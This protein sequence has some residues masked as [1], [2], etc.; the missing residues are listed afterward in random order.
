MAEQP[1][2]KRERYVG[3]SAYCLQLAKVSSD[4]KSRNTLRQM[5]SEWLK[6]AE[7][8]IE[9]GLTTTTDG[10]PQTPRSSAQRRPRLCRRCARVFTEP[11]KIKRDGIAMK[12][13]RALREHQGPRE[14]KVTAQRRQ[15]YVDG[16]ERQRITCCSAVN[17]RASAT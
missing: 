10:H 12:Q 3:Y 4:I 11:K 15:S 13:L 2:D 14:K 16:N 9:P 5:A 17:T 7:E 8:S 6:L 1:T